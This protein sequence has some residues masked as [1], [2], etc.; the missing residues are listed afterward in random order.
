MAS[1]SAYPRHLPARRWEPCEVLSIQDDGYCVCY[2][3]SGRHMC[4]NV[5]E[6]EDLDAADRL[7]DTMAMDDPDAEL[8]EPLLLRLAEHLSCRSEH[9]EQARELV[10]NW[11]AE[12]DEYAM[13]RRM[14]RPVDSPHSSA[15]SA[16]GESI[17]D[18][19]AQMQMVLRATRRQV[20]GTISRVSTAD[21]PSLNLA[22]T[23][24]LQSATTAVASSPPQTDHS[25]WSS[26]NPDTTG[27]SSQACTRDHVQ[28]RP[29]DTMC[30]ICW[31]EYLP[32]DETVWCKNGC[33]RTV[34]RQCFEHWRDACQTEGLTAPC[35]ICRAAWFPECDCA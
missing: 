19:I 20:Q 24:T 30:P 12:V 23:P 34:H 31:E 26:Q 21:I 5:L 29:R 16:Y 4:Q 1:P 25:S 6:P 22:R 7:L 17:H 3:A 27:N 28:R 11:Q 8:L 35:G 33:G 13:S 15:D 18:T 10:V 2:N 14:L 32:E 9:Q